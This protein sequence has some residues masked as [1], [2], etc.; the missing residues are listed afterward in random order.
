MTCKS[1]LLSAGF[2]SPLCLLPGVLLEIERS[3]DVKAPLKY[4]ILV[5]CPAPSTLTIQY[6]QAL[7]SPTSSQPGAM[8]Q[9]QG[10]NFPRYKSINCKHDF[11]KVI[12]S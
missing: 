1:C 8:C 5:A 2:S 12:L 4:V 6:A 10:C 11:E 9:R 3:T 7:V